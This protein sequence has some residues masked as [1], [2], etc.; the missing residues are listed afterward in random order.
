MFTVPLP[1]KPF[2]SPDGGIHNHS[3]DE[4]YVILSSS[5]I[6][7]LKAFLE[8]N[9]IGHKAVVGR[10]KGKL[11]SSYIINARNLDEIQLAKAGFIDDQ[12]SILYLTPHSYGYAN[13]DEKNR[14]AILYFNSPSIPPRELGVFRAVNQDKV[15]D[16]DYSYDPTINTF[17]MVFDHANNPVNG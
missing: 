16:N 4:R 13:Y 6:E 17:F 5:K 9:G 15:K 1:E 11:E 14:V 7:E 12:E 2:V 3:S 8:N 10:Y